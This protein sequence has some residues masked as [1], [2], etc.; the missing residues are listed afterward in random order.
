MRI[1][2]W[3]SDVC[4]SDLLGQLSDGAGIK[5]SFSGNC[6]W[7]RQNPGYCTFFFT[8]GRFDDSI[9]NRFQAGC[10]LSCMPST[11]QKIN[12]SN[13]GYEIFQQ[14]KWRVAGCGASTGEDRKS[15]RLNSSH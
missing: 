6:K 11:K 5:P 15:T 3:S 4:S 10:G 12:R 9:F 14:R 13:C 1:S 8:G 7:P 2:D